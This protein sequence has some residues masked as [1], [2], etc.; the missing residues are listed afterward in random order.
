VS[1]VAVPT[2]FLMGSAEREVV[3]DRV[4]VSVS[5]HTPVMRS[6]QEALSRA[7]EARR[8]LLDHLAAGL[9]GS[10]I[11]DGRTTTH[12]EERR[13]EEERPGRTETRYEVAGYTGL[14]LV[15]VED[16]AGRAAEIVANAGAHPDAERVSPRFH[17]GPAL[18][19]RVR[20]ELEQEAVRDALARA[21]G[22]ADAAGMAVGPVVSIGEYGPPPPAPDDGGMVYRAS[23]LS[24]DVPVDQ[25]REALGELTNRQLVARC[26]RMHRSPRR[27]TV[28]ATRAALRSRAAEGAPAMRAFGERL[29]ELDLESRRHEVQNLPTLDDARRRE[30]LR[31]ADNCGR[32]MRAADLESLPARAALLRAAQVPDDYSTALRIAGVK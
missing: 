14:C 29:A 15:T 32:L 23:Q 30:T 3:P 25:L 7:A 4:V 9:P 19:R 8:R 21:Q 16:E 22:L 27:D 20:D 17:V 24:P 12:Q 31:R 13:V 6:P 1:A 26:A 28:A 5:V 18:G 10:A 11:T 2:L